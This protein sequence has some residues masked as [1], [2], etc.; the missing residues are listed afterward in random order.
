MFFKALIVAG[1]KK[2]LYGI[3]GAFAAGLVILTDQTPPP[4]DEIGQLLWQLAVV[5][6]VTFVAGALSRW[7]NYKPE[8]AGK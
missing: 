6:G 5:P 3:A 2:A 4:P 8:L 7:A 1:I